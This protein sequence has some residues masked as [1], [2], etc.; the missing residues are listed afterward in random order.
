MCELL[1]DGRAVAIFPEGRINAEEAD[2]DL[3]RG[4]AFMALRCGCPILPVYISHRESKGQRLH[5]VVGE[6]IYGDRVCEGLPRAE[7]VDVLSAH[8]KSKAAEFED[9]Y[10][11]ICKR[12]THG[13]V[14]SRTGK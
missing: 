7:R 4:T 2:I 3:K 14:G 10:R 6:P 11:E 13:A 12:E 9:Y 1:Q 8:L 5:I